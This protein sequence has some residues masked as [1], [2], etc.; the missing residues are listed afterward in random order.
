MRSVYFSGKPIIERGKAHFDEPGANAVSFCKSESKLSL[1]INE[2][3]LAPDQG[4]VVMT[5]F[6]FCLT[7]RV[8]EVSRMTYLHIK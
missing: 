2:I 8:K 5:E 1:S 3:R 6:Y 4:R 7:R